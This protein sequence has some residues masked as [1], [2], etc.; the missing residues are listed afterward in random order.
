VILDFTGYLAERAEEF[1]GREWVIDA[2]TAWRVDPTGERCFLIIGEPGVGKTAV[3][4]RLA[5]EARWVDAMHFCSARDRRW[6]NPRTF[7]ESVSDQL[8]ATK[9]AFAT[10]L[11]R[12][13]APNVAIQQTVAGDNVGRLVGVE[14]LVV[15]GSAEDV[16][17]RLVR[18]PIEAVTEPTILLI[19]AL[20]ESL[21]YSGSVTIADLVA[22]SEHLPQP[23]RFVLTCRPL[24]DLVRMLRRSGA[25]ECVLSARDGPSRDLALH[26][27]ERYVAR[28]APSFE[29]APELSVPQF[30]AAVRDRSGGNFLYTRHL[31]HNL[32]QQ[33]GPVTRAAISGLPRSLNG[34][35]LD[36]LHHLAGQAQGQRYREISAVLSILA[37]AQ[38]PLDEDRIAWFTRLPAATV[39]GALTDLRQFLHTDDTMPAAARTYALYHTSFG[40]LMLDRDRAEEYWVDG[41]TAHHAIADAYLDA[42]RG[43][44]SGCDDYGLNSL[45]THL[46]EAGDVGPLQ[47]LLDA[48]WIAERRARRNGGYDG[49]LGDLDLAW[50][51]A[52]HADL[53]AV[54]AGRPAQHLADEV[55]WALAVASVGTGVLPTTLLRELA[56]TGVWTAEQALGYARLY[57]SVPDRAEALAGLAAALPEPLRGDARREAVAIAEGLVAAGLESAAVRRVAVLAGLI[58]LL[59]LDLR[60][61]SARAAL[62]NARQLSD[63]RRVALGNIGYYGSEFGE[64]SQRT[65]LRSSALEQIA[66]ALERAGWPGDETELRAELQRVFGLPDEAA[67]NEATTSLLARLTDASPPEAEYARPEPVTDARRDDVRRQLAEAA[68]QPINDIELRAATGSALAGPRPFTGT[69]LEGASATSERSPSVARAGWPAAAMDDPA[70]T[71][72]ELI[73]TAPS[74]YSASNVTDQAAPYQA[75]V[76]TALAGHLPAGLMMEALEFA[77]RISEPAARFRAVRALGPFLTEPALRSVIAR[78]QPDSRDVARRLASLT[79]VMPGPLLLEALTAVRRTDDDTRVAG[80]AVLASHLPEPQASGVASALAEWLATIDTANPAG[81]DALAAAAGYLPASLAARGFAALRAAAQAADGWFG[82]DRQIVTA[83]LA[84]ARYLTGPDRTEALRLVQTAAEGSTWRTWSWGSMDAQSSIFAALDLGRELPPSPERDQILRTLAHQAIVEAR[85]ATYG[86]NYE[87]WNLRYRIGLFIV[88]LPHLPEPYRSEAAEIV[89]RMIVDKSTEPLPVHQTASLAAYLPAQLLSAAERAITEAPLPL[90]LPEESLAA[91][92]DIARQRA[93]TDW[94]FAVADRGLL[95][96]CLTVAGEMGGPL[97]R[98]ELITRHAHQLSKFP[99]PELYDVWTA[100]LHDLAGF[101]RPLLLLYLRDMGPI[102]TA[103]SGPDGVTAV[104]DAIEVV[105][106]IWP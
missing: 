61:R 89:V 42:H 77:E 9:P 11:L 36:F 19:D 96:E 103:L 7:A 100:T 63:E 43:D 54:A 45:A 69:A 14:T 23:V 29:L 75:A 20:D 2:V 93:N 59:P 90:F 87:T 38:Q 41:R 70:A 80:L 26:D 56:F 99:P 78:I 98:I 53:S 12:R 97:L 24:P 33:D 88:L 101:E 72:G 35:Y 85:T 8:A 49:V 68:R 95:P 92:L 31:L 57:R 5:A 50:R 16:F 44:W 84:L 105:A 37:V 47:S 15:D 17:D 21:A 102:I 82:P 40:D 13:S 48:A 39:R 73:R 22:Q 74:P 81:R 52:E 30:V 65:G 79:D 6:I 55:R 91:A 67:F 34:V 62:G 86:R 25:R 60:R 64:L 71:L 83:I 76:L 94:L 1:T 58:P 32:E 104:A 51:A 46:Y 10:A 27:V 4:A 28:L 66:A 18:A 106:N 3:A